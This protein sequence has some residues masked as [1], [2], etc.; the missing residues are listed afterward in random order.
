MGNFFSSEDGVKY[1]ESKNHHS[2][3]RLYRHIEDEGLH[4]EE[5]SKASAYYT[6]YTKQDDYRVEEQSQHPKA[7]WLQPQVVSPLKPGVQKNISREIEAANNDPWLYHYDAWEEQ[8]V[9]SWEDSCSA[10][11]HYWYQRDDYEVEDL[12]HFGKWCKQKKSTGLIQPPKKQG[13]RRRRTR[14]GR[15]DLGEDDYHAGH[16][17]KEIKEKRLES[18]AKYQSQYL[19]SIAASK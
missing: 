13:R 17:R 11:K 1:K 12:S 4:W 15:G 8:Y 16:S 9:S 10:Q 5:P 18:D 2:Q 6:R 7:D 19:K 3:E 14:K